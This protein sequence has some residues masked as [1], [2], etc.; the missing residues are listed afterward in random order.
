MEAITFAYLG[1][2][3]GMVICQMVLR[4]AFAIAVVFE[5][6]WTYGDVP[7]ERR[8][9]IWALPLVLFLHS[10]PWMLVVVSLILVHLADTSHSAAWNWLAGGTLSGAGLLALATGVKLGRLRRMRAARYVNAQV[11]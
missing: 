6:R 1:F 5:K 10:G 11:A 9:L 4:W 2:F 7:V 3:V 8:T